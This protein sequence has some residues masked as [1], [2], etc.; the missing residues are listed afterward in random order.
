MSSYTSLAVVVNEL[1]FFENCEID[2]VFQKWLRL[3]N[4]GSRPQV[5]PIP[6]MGQWW[7]P[8]KPIWPIV[9]DSIPVCIVGLI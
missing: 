6:V 3:D 7:R 1:T 4:Y 2:F 8:F 9:I 5:N